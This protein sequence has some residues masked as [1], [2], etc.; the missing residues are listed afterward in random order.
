A[1][2]DDLSSPALPVRRSRALRHL[3][4]FPTRRSSDLV[5]TG[6]PVRRWTS[7]AISMWALARGVMPSWSV[8]TLTRPARAG[9]VKVATDHDGMTPR[10]KAH[11]EMAAEV[12]RRT[13]APVLTR[14]EE[15]RVGKEGRC[16]RARERRTGRAGELRS[17]TS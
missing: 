3:P 6:A 4:S 13:G 16:R 1:D 17:S 8:A 2:V 9:L 14:S 15:R 5:N 12:H 10:A 7:A 11:M